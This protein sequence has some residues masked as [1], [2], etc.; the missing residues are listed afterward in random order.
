MQLFILRHVHI[1]LK[2]RFV[3]NKETFSIVL[4]WNVILFIALVQDNVTYT[5]LIQVSGWASETEI[6][7]FLSL[8]QMVCSSCVLQNVLTV[9]HDCDKM[10]LSHNNL[11][12]TKVFEL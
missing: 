9:R 8:F 10:F 12:P 5:I 7:L 11:R 2:K 1:V 3:M 4:I 6:I